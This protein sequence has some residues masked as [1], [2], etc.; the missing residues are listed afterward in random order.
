MESNFVGN[1]E[2]RLYIINKLPHYGNEDPIADELAARLAAS[3]Q[4]LSKN[5]LI[6]WDKNMPGTFSYITHAT[7]GTYTGTTFDGRIAGT[8]LSDGCGPVQGRDLNGPT[9]MLRSL[10]SWDQSAL[11]G[12]M[13]V[14][15]K[16]SKSNFDI[17][18]QQNLVA[19]IKTFMERGGI[20]FQINV[21]DREI[22]LDAKANP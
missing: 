19:L 5:D 20:E 4:K 14:N 21:V 18:K 2:L 8:S 3:I 1:E 11:L 15:L 6:L 10:T 17:E 16:L 9:T 13:V 12:G 7:M 22:L